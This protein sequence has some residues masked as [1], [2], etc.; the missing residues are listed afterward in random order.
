MG[1]PYVWKNKII[2]RLPCEINNR[3]YGL[4]EAAKW[5]KNKKHIGF[6]L[7]NHR[8]SFAQL[9]KMTTDVDVEIKESDG[10]DVP[11]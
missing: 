2:F 3:C 4:L 5:I 10:I 6:V 9:K 7:G 8:K 1:K 11:F